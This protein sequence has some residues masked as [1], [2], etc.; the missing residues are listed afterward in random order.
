MTGRYTVRYGMQYSTAIL[1]GQPWGVPLSEKV[2]PFLSLGVC[3][4]SLRFS[5]QRDGQPDDVDIYRRHT[6]EHVNEGNFGFV[7]VD[8][9]L[10]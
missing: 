7:L 3:R 5:G 10:S 1:P 4:D 9:S 8:C 6:W 2:L